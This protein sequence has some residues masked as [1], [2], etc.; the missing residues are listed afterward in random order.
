M[1][2]DLLHQTAARAETW[3]RDIALPFWLE[4]GLDPMGMAWEEMSFDGTPRET[5]YR[6]T[7]VQFR[8]VYVFAH[9]AHAG[10]CPPENACALFFSTCVRA[11]HPEGGFVHRLSP[12][13]DVLDPTRDAYDHAFALLAAGWI[14][15]VS[16][17]ERALA[18]ARE[19]LAFM[20]GKM[21]HPQ[22]GFV[23]A[24]PT[25]TPRR[26]NPHMHIFEALLVLFEASG[27]AAFIDAARD[28]LRLFKSRFI[29][30]GGGLLEYFDGGWTP[31]KVRDQFIVEPGH[32][33]EWTWLLHE[34]ERLTGE[35]QAE[36]IGQL[37]QFLKPDGID[38]EGLAVAELDE[39]G[40][41][42][43]PAR[44]LWAQTEALK[45]YIIEAQRAGKVDEARIPAMVEAI[46]G[47]FLITDPAPLWYE[48]IE[49]GGAPIRKRMPATTLY[50]LTL[51]FME[52]RRFSAMSGR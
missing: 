24:L 48:G 15:R 1:S 8:Q 22:G 9:A 37:M 43:N 14:Y 47:Y 17:D 42:I 19:T 35:D 49:A 26:Q 25:R 29:A 13:G 44:M 7:L 21:A 6:R 20:Q 51:A 30:P 52:L 31:V 27:E 40:R 28:V 23:E 12:D 11:R 33:F 50:H 10:W 5:G 16:A 3:L 4:N 45:A 46:F 36:F 34:F 39:A 41:V 2:S 32:H 38:A 18:V